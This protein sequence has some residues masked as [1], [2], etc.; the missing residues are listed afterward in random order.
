MWK[1]GLLTREKLSMWWWNIHVNG[2][3]KT[4]LVKAPILRRTVSSCLSIP[5][6]GL[7][8]WTGQGWCWHDSLC[9]S[10]S[11]RVCVCVCVGVGRWRVLGVGK[12]VCVWWG[13]GDSKAFQE[14]ESLETLGWSWVQTLAP[15]FQ[16]EI[17]SMVIRHLPLRQ[18]GKEFA[19]LKTPACRDENQEETA[20]FPATPHP[21]PQGSWGPWWEVAFPWASV[22]SATHCWFE[23]PGLFLTVFYP[24]VWMIYHQEITFYLWTLKTAVTFW[25]KMAE[26]GRETEQ[27]CVIL[28]K[29]NLHGTENNWKLKSLF[30]ENGCSFI[31][32]LHIVILLGSERGP[33]W[34]LWL[35]FLCEWG[36]WESERLWFAQG[37]TISKWQVWD[38][39]KCAFCIMTILWQLSRNELFRGLTIKNPPAG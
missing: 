1:S 3:F 29:G 6:S 22:A 35:L 18:M 2:I 31:T 25:G 20:G 26:R 15:A 17:R 10:V 21:H 5:V 19:F 12:G 33:R 37:H 14:H 36:D 8:C 34:A 23:H 16:R 32:D 39:I 28:L 7:G 13:K 4:G 38:S 27:G 11:S 24:L 9:L 30:Y